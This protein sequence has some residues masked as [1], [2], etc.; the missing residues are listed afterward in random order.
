LQRK[1]Y[2]VTMC[3]MGISREVLNSTSPTFPT[4]DVKRIITDHMKSM[5]DI[6]SRG[7]SVQ[8]A[9]LYQK[10]AKGGTK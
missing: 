7:Y 3:I 6:L 2:T 1:L 5:V 4:G 10:E 9:E 8:F